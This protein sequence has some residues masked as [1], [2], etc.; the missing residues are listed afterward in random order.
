MKRKWIIAI[1]VFVVLLMV[2]NIVYNRLGEYK[3]ERILYVKSLDFHFSASV[4]SLEIFWGTNGYVYFHTTFGEVDLLTEEQKNGNLKVNSSLRFLL[5]M[6]NG[7]LAFH[8]RDLDK[9]Q[10]SDSIIIDS[11]VDRIYIFRQGKLTGESQI[12]KELNGI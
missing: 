3:D 8:A 10:P 9:Y 1:V 6:D 11:D 7:A 5:P 4:D 2:A 12:W